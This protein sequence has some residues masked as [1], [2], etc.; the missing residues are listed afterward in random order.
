MQTMREEEEIL[1][2][3]EAADEKPSRA[4]RKKTDK[5]RA[6]VYRMESGRA[7]EQGSFPEA[8]VG[9][10]L[11]RRMPTFLKEMFG[12]GEYKIEVRK[13]NGR[14]EKAFDLSIVEEA[15][16]VSRH[17]DIEIDAEPDETDDS[18][19]ADF[20]EPA[21][22]M[23]TVAVE[24]LLL[25]ERLKR[26]EDEVSRQRTGNQ[27]ET[28]TLI[29][30][31]EQSRQEQREL[32]MLMLRQAQQPPQDAT[33]QAMNILEKSLGIVTKAKAISEEIAP[34]GSN[35]TGSGSLLSDGAKL[36][37]S[38]GRNA[39][40]FLP[41]IMAGARSPHPPRAAAATAPAGPPNGNT[42]SA[43]ELSNLASRIQKK[44]AQGNE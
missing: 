21:G 32:M 9:E 4:R 16:E 20:Q 19:Y 26:I 24:N 42:T 3:E 41:L 37:D 15:E 33:A 44:E 29:A 30:A 35:E 31:L 1:R 40:T 28:Q 10:P 38:L 7:K 22:R 34:N 12:P 2:G 6:F 23:N 5:R 36:I 43:G 27:T 18:I 39:G 14:F 17:G 25:K 11:E 8:V 13:D